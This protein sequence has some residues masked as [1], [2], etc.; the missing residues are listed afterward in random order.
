MGQTRPLYHRLRAGLVA[1]LFLLF[2]AGAA[3]QEEASEATEPPAAAAD[4]ERLQESVGVRREANVE[5]QASQKKVDEISSET[6]QIF[7]RFSNA[8]RQADSTR[9]YNSQMRQLITSQEAELASLADQ[10]DRVEVV[11]R[12]VTPLMLRMIEGLE[13]FVKLDVPFLMDERLARIAELRQL[14][15]RADVSKSEQFRQILEAYQIEIEYGRL[16]EAYRSTLDRDGKK[17]TVDFLRFGRIALIYQTLDGS[18][19]GVWDQANRQWE[20]LDSSYRSAIREG[21]RIARKQAAPDLIRLPL[22]AAV[23][24]EET[25]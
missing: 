9:V 22:P 4:E 7:S 25:G 23:D 13:A 19:A 6:E 3:A 1:G 18:E 17:I 14:M 11:G 15:T 8:L 5:G 10:I 20:P 16:I 2:A 12:S 21:L 24:S